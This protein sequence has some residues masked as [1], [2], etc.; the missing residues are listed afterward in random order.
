MFGKIV[1]SL[2]LL[3]G[4]AGAARAE[5]LPLPEPGEN[6]WGLGATG[7]MCYQEPC[8]RYG[9]FRIYQDGRFELPLSRRN[10][11]QP[12]PLRADERDRARIDWAFETGGC[13]MAEGHFEGRTLVVRRV[14]GDCHD[15]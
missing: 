15:L 5:L 8:P 12:P 11:S 13:V 10:Q 14:W 3:L 6:L 9:V 1:F 4:L 7:I 2:T